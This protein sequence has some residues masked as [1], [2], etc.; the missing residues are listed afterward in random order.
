VESNV[1]QRKLSLVAG[2]V[3]G[4]GGQRIP[5]AELVGRGSCSAQAN[6]RRRVL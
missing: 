1:A 5:I 6:P 4:G 2:N 3:T